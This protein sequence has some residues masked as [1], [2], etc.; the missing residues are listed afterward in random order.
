M[1][2]DDFIEYVK[3]NLGD[4]YRDVMLAEAANGDAM[5]LDN[6]RTKSLDVTVQRVMKNNGIMLDAVSIYEE[7]ERISPNIY[8]KP[9]YDS[10]LM[11]KP[12]DFVLTEI[13][14]R[15][16]N[17]KAES[18]FDY[19]NFEDYDRVKDKLVFRLINF[20][21]NKELLSGCPYIE[22]LDLAITFR[23]VIDESVLGLASILI[24]DREF[25]KWDVNVDELY[26]QALFNSIQ[27]NPWCMEPL[28]KIV[29]DSFDERLRDKLTPELLDELDSIKR[30]GLGV[31]LYI[32]TNQSKA[33]G[34]G[35]I[36]YDN[37]IR[38]FAR[39]QEANV[40]ILPS[41]VHEV[42]LVPEDDDIS[43]EFL[44]D[45]LLEANRSSVGLI[46]LLS[47]NLYYF[48]RQRDEITIFNV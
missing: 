34:A 29:F 22:Y 33:F 44:L 47:D 36:L 11:G 35:C 27:R 32:M 30:Y 43:P 48:D 20:E 2:Y 5:N 3:E 38:N 6:I 13:I 7:G 18:D 41:S 8:L 12:L 31:N 9:F 23:Y 40:Y 10:Y 46:D 16:R 24:T 14:F 4:C 19:I 25:E 1:N 28:S 21:R 37:V 42:M 15:Y 26:R 45:L 39:V 17:E